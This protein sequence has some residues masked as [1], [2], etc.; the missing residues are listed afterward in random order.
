MTRDD[1][2]FKDDFDFKGLLSGQVTED[3]RK[4]LL[5]EELKMRS[6][7]P[8]PWTEIKY[9]KYANFGRNRNKKT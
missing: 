8:K 9:R 3:L 7:Q 6:K 2:S 5:A 4:K 1:P